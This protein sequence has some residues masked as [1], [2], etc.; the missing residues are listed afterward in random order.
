MIY[1]FEF[2]RTCKNGRRRTVHIAPQALDTLPEASMLADA[3]LK[4]TTFLGVMADIVIIK[5]QTGKFV[6][7]LTTNASRRKR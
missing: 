7:E 6:G 1:T 2:L 4:N 5:D 3:M